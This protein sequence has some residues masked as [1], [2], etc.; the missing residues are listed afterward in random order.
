ML[1][2]IKK[3]IIL[4][5][6]LSLV[7]L[8]SCDTATTQE[9]GKQAENR[10]DAVYKL[11]NKNQVRKYVMKYKGELGI[12]KQ[13]AEIDT[14]IKDKHKDYTPEIGSRTDDAIEINHRYIKHN[15]QHYIEVDVIYKVVFTHKEMAGIV[16][17]VKHRPME[18]DIGKT[19]IKLNL[20][21]NEDGFLLKGRKLVDELE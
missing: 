14:L 17:V 15:N 20:D 16:P 5:L 2:F 13:M 7:I 8:A 3:I 10:V 19:Y 6:S 11:L 18:Y 1:K 12:D 21:W 4:L 9:A